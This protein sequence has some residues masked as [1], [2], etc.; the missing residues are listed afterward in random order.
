[1]KRFTIRGTVT[2]S[3]WTV[4]EAESAEDAKRIAFRRD[5]ADVHIDGSY[6]D[7]EFW[8]IDT[9]GAPDIDRAEVD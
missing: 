5:M 8:H 6:P 2:V 7:D 3:C 4:V 9:D 1:V